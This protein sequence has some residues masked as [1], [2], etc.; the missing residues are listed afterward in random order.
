MGDSRKPPE[1]RTKYIL[2]THI[3][4]ENWLDDIGGLCLSIKLTLTSKIS[5]SL[6]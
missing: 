6:S 1:G 2:W 4:P 5:F 3:F